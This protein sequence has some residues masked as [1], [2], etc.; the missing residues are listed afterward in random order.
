MASGAAGQ[1]KL[2]LQE[3]FFVPLVV[4]MGTLAF[5]AQSTKMVIAI[6]RH[7]QEGSLSVCLSLSVSLPVSVCLPVSVSLWLCL[8]VCLCLSVSLC[9][10]LSL[11]LALALALS[12]CGSVCLSLYISTNSY[13]PHLYLTL[14]LL[15]GH[16]RT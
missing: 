5:Y 13:K 1:I 7:L 3:S 12:L 9:V 11:S 16:W 14:A 4:G 10:C 8:S 6:R 2:N 15:H